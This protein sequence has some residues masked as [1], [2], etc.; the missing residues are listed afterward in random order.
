[1]R[2]ED[3]RLA[4]ISRQIALLSANIAAAM[5]DITSRLE[6]IERL[7]REPAAPGYS[8]C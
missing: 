4:E 5:A 3:E 6:T 1:M 2:D 8:C 7:L